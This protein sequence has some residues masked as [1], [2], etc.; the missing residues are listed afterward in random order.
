MLLAE[1]PHSS[2]SRVSIFN[3]QIQTGLNAL[4]VRDWDI[5]ESKTDLS[6]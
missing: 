5:R 1:S 2:V 4:I 6:R 3:F